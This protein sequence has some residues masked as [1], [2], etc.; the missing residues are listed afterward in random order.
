MLEETTA[1]LSVV[2]PTFNE[3][4]N[5][6]QCLDSIA[7]WVDEIVVV[8]SGSTDGTLEIARRY[9]DRIVSH[10]YENAPK[11][12]EWILANASLSNEWVLGL[13]AD[14]R[15]TPELR[16]AIQSALRS[17]SSST[18]GY[19]VRHKQIF[20][21]QFIKHG[22]IYPRYRLCLFRKDRVF[23]DETDLVDNRFYVHGRT[24]KLEFDIIE[25]NQKEVSFQTWVRKQ[26][27][28]AERAAEEELNR[29][30]GPFSQRGSWRKGRNERVLWLKTR[31]L[32]LPLYWRSVG[33]FLYRY[34][35][36]LG[37][38]DGRAGFLYHFSQAL[39]FRIML[40]A[41]LEEL[42]SSPKK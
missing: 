16:T 42:K 26:I 20:R 2:I 29:S 12:W 19:Y 6:K 14:Y 8:D 36:R 22:G 1:E 35:F 41:R 10:E 27:T 3:E 38:L 40:D 24:E 39:L 23:V 4:I 7:S 5:L 34:I 32:R 18:D 9:T 33:Y 15:V 21:G 11:Q 37:F 28:Y 17:P 13:D 30:N 31:W 25:D